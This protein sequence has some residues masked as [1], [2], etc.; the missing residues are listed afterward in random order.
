[1]FRVQIWRQWASF[2]FRKGKSS[3]GNRGER[4]A[5]NYLKSELQ[6]RLIARNWRNP[7]NRREE[8]DLVCLDQGVLVFVEVKAR[9]GTDP[10]EGY[11]AVNARKRRVLRRACRA[12]LRRYA[13]R[14]RSQSYRLDV[15]V[16][17]LEAQGR[18]GEIFHFR[19]LPLF[20]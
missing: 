7:W 19:N 18:V 13:P 9:S 3:A 11:H 16:V 17:S 12:Y 6:F 5:A 10:L 20:S 8:I 1:M 15:V 14:D 2:F 4:A